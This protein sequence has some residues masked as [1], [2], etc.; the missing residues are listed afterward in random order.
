VAPAGDGQV[1]Y[2]GHRF[3]ATDIQ[4]LAVKL[5]TRRAE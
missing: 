1:S 2:E 4:R 5:Q 3:A